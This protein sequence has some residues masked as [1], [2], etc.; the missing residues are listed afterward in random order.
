MGLSDRGCT[1]CGG[2]GWIPGPGRKKV[3]CPGDVSA[4]R[5]GT[6]QPAGAGGPAFPASAPPA[7]ASVDAVY[8]RFQ[9]MQVPAAPTVETSVVGDPS[10]DG[11]LTINAYRDGTRVGYLQLQST[12]RGRDFEV[13][14]V[15]VDPNH[16]RQGI[17]RAMWQQAV[18]L[19]I[20]PVHSARRT[21]DGEAFAR[22]M[23]GPTP[24]N[25]HGLTGEELETAIAAVREF[26]EARG[27]RRRP[28]NFVE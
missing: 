18:D 2:T 10:A 3:R 20:Q 5:A 28:A 15:G 11:S 21:E 8:A 25:I 27:P 4:P 24:P 26:D 6:P 23:G 12:R 16:R 9:Q 19:G 7:P 22:A 14:K 13:I 1:R 17:A